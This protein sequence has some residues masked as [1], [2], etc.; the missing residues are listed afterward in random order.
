VKSHHPHLSTED[1]DLLLRSGTGDGPNLDAARLRGLRQH[2]GSC[3]ACRQRL[4]QQEENELPLHD[5]KAK[6]AAT[7]DACPPRSGWYLV[8]AGLLPD[9]EAR[10][11]LIHAGLCAHCGPLLQQAIEDFSDELS[12][13]EEKQIAA[14]QSG[15]PHWQQELAVRLGQNS[16][17]SET[18]SRPEAAQQ[19]LPGWREASVAVAVICAVIVVFLWSRALRRQ[20][21]DDL[22]AQAYSEQRTI[23]LR[24]P[25]AR[26]A[27]MR[28]ERSEGGRSRLNAPAALLDVEAQA[29]RR[30]SANPE[31]P[32]WL[33]ISGNTELLE[34]NYDAAIARFSKALDSQPEQSTLR[35][36]LASAYSERAESLGRPADYALAAETLG[37]LLASE[38]DNA[39]ALFNRALIME[40]MYL[41]SQAVNDWEHYLR[42]DPTGDWAAEAR[43]RLHALQEKLKRRGSLNAA[44]LLAPSAV[45][46]EVSRRDPATWTILDQQVEPYL[47]LAITQWLPRASGTG[48]R[49]DSRAAAEILATVLQVD[50][51]DPW[52]GDLLAG[53]RTPG[54]S[55]A[56][57]ALA[58]S[59]QDSA[60]GEYG[61]S[62]S[63]ASEAQRRFEAMGNRAGA[64]RA[65]LEQVYALGLSQ[66][67]SACSHAADALAPAADASQYRWI[68]TQLKLER[69]VCYDLLGD[70]G[71][72]RV[73]AATAL[74]TAEQSGYPVLELR[75]LDFMAGFDLAA[76]R[77][78]SAWAQATTG[79]ARWWGHRYPA[80]PLHNLYALAD[81]LA[82]AGQQWHLDVA[83]TRQMVATL[84]GTDNLRLAAMSHD[85]LAKAALMAGLPNLARSEF[86]EAA[87]LFHAS[88]P[89]EATRNS[90][91]EA[92]VELAKLEM[93]RGDTS[94]AGRHL[95]SVA[96]RVPNISSRFIAIGFYRARGQLDRAQRDAAGAEA[97]LRAAVAL[98]ERE[99][100]SLRLEEDR[101]A[102]ERQTSDTYHDL[103]QLNWTQHDPLQALEA[104]EWYRGA[105]VRSRYP[106]RQPVH[107]LSARTPVGAF[108]SLHLVSDLLPWLDRQTI[109][110]YAVF[111]Q[112][113][114]VWVSDNRGVQARWIAVPRERI[115]HLAQHFRELCSDPSSNPAT[116]RQEARALYDLL[117]APIAGRLVR[118]RTLIV[119]ADDALAEIPFATLVDTQGRYLLDSYSFVYSPGVYLAARLR[120]A[121]PITAHGSALVVGPGS[122]SR[123]FRPLPDATR[124]AE[125]VAA[126]FLSARLLTGKTATVQ[127]VERD[128]P[129]AVV[130]HFAGHARNS[131]EQI[132]LV[133][134]TADAF[135]SPLLTSAG[136]AM[137]RPKLQL[138]V[139]S[140]CTT[141]G[142]DAGA[143]SL[144]QALLQAGVPHVVAARWNVDSAATAAF[145]EHFYGAV[146][147]G[148]SV[149]ASLQSA[150]LQT[151]NTP[152]SSHPYYWSPF[153]LLGRD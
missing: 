123:E 95:D 77:T 27:P 7:R 87:R 108:S 57:G 119:E 15:R 150:A 83:V 136:L 147:T 17:A 72:A 115:Q 106:T 144:S 44:P 1:I 10:P 16:P 67:G 64:L 129:D 45:S 63:A 101:R 104:W 39:L 4:R 38:P 100:R 145:M 113:I 130:F 96:A 56:A 70:I 94:S 60:R 131:V 74:G 118:D 26:H 66:N 112:G 121:A 82:A 117:V 49:A 151:R 139:L 23:E 30:L 31:D 25:L 125:N 120:R 71:T 69:A 138:A 79:M 152:A 133:L 14:L 40:R 59:L 41:F 62:R 53:S 47:D 80:Q 92:T 116:L 68:S 12:P 84:A 37:K 97:S 36:G 110:T 11:K 52:M 8:A 35:L 43:E 19:T 132:G 134:A 29:K 85:R 122:S 81:D 140:A 33:G 126:K 105:A 55:R 28:V 13:Q 18:G 103:V 153:Y 109:L 51:R 75:A 93:Q 9:A 50:H 32:L 58:R 2:I 65:R 46:R 21:P 89:G 111:S 22:L 3:G 42:V 88:P 148:N 128:M 90:E 124:E 78:A 137:R 102:W 114:A 107:L 76:G 24:I 143:G 73:L 86:S 91:V 34:W 127:N 146:L 61:A 6:A 135:Q 54:F 48:A 20:S 142:S 149:A 98:S 141:E 5:L 99:L